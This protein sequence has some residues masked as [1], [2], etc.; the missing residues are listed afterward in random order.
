MAAKNWVGSQKN[1]KIHNMLWKM[2]EMAEMSKGIISHFMKY[3]Y[4]LSC[5]KTDTL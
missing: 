1:L 4:L 3:A 5:V 2:A